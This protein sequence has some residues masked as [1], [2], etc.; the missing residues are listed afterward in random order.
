MKPLVEVVVVRPVKYSGRTHP[1]GTQL[2]LSS[3]VAMAFIDAG[4]CV[5]KPKE[6]ENKKEK[7]QKEKNSVEVQ[8]EADGLEISKIV[9]NHAEDIE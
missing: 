5:L 6:E 4:I 9:S 7:K 2:S 3:D 8:L 1:A